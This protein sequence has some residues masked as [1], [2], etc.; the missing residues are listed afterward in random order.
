M[1]K[2]YPEHL[3][4]NFSDHITKIFCSLCRNLDGFHYNFVANWLNIWYHL[5][6]LTPISIRLNTFIEKIEDL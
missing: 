6:Q 2:E 5:V 3:E 1:A 4:I